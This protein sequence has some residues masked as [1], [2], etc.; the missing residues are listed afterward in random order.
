MD[1]GEL[2]ENTK[3]AQEPQNHGN[4]HDGIQNRLYGTRHGDEPVDEPEK[5]THHDQDHYHLN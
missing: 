1:G 5:N 3:N 4:D 2:T